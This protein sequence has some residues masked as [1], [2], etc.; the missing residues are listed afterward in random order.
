VFFQK[1]LQSSFSREILLDHCACPPLFITK[2]EADTGMDRFEA[3]V[4]KVF[5]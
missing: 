3:A 2:E 1:A 4:K 5:A